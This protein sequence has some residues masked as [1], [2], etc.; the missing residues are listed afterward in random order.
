MI[1]HQKQLRFLKKLAERDRIPHALL[2]SGPAKVGKKTAAREWAETLLGEPLKNGWHPDLIL[3]EPDEGKEI[4]IGQVREL[5]W[6]LSLRPYSAKVKVAIID[7][8]QTMNF[9]SQNCFLK[10]LEEPGSNTI[11]ILISEY[12]DRLL[13]TIRS[14][15]ETIKFYPVAKKEME[16]HFPEE[17]LAVSLG[18]PGLAKDLIS[19]PDKLEN[20]NKTREDFSVLTKK[21]LAFR[22]QYAQNMAEKENP[23]DI[24]DILD[25]W[26]FFLRD[27]LLANFKIIKKIQEINYLIQNTNVSKRLALETL[28][29][30]I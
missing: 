11:L 29:L 2:F 14:R 24:K 12:P 13:A 1:G 5:I 23:A 25:T 28:M 27:N 6:K 22:F 8:A 26:I 3:L 10:T 21:D 30:E 18:R 4:K 16:E 17:I 15:C 20:F 19:S 9:E 7:E